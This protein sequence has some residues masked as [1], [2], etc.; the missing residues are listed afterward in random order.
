MEGNDEDFTDDDNYDVE[1]D[2]GVD[3]DSDV[4]PSLSTSSV[5]SMLERM[6]DLQATH[7]EM[8]QPCGLTSMNFGV[9]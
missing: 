3:V 5:Q 2:L 1:A 4:G 8:M 6:L 7:G 9:Q